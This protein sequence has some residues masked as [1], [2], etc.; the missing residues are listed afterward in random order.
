MLL[1]LLHQAQHAVPA[2]ALQPH[3]QH[4]QWL[5]QEQQQ[6]Q[7]SPFDQLSLAAPACV[8]LQPPERSLSPNSQLS[9]QMSGQ[10]SSTMAEL[11][12]QS[13]AA[14]DRRTSS[15]AVAL[16]PPPAVAA[17][18]P[19]APPGVPGASG[20]LA[21]LPALPKL[22]EEQ[23]LLYVGSVARDPAATQR[24]VQLARRVRETLAGLVTMVTR[25]AAHGKGGGQ[26]VD[27][28]PSERAA[29]RK[30]S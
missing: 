23:M 15:A 6:A 4:E 10:L 19:S 16:P 8:P 24:G 13:L 3:L 21:N 1:Q 27:G 12:Q 2:Q 20:L 22:V 29:K 30:A 14:A 7:P 26:A 25:A 28:A 18:L 11:G 5:A 9:A 17:R